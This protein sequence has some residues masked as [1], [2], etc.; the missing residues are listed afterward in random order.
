[1]TKVQARLIGPEEELGQV[2]SVEFFGQTVTREFS[3]IEL[4]KEQIE[5]ANGN[6]FIEL[7][8][9]KLPKTDE[10]AEA[11]TI[12]DRLNELNEPVKDDAAVRTVRAKVAPAEKA[13]AKR[14]A[15]AE[16][17]AEE[18][19]QAADHAKV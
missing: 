18:A 1:M 11:E 6:R 10:K 8:G 4:T 16:A 13:Q 3:P 17:K 15:E 2:S 19:A 5:K 9:Q 14:E 7:K 12:R